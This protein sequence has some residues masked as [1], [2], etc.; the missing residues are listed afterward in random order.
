MFKS[1]LHGLLLLLALPTCVTEARAEKFKAILRRVEPE[2][3]IVHVTRAEPADDKEL[4]YSIVADARIIRGNGQKPLPDGLRDKLFVPGAQVTL[5]TRT[6]NG[7][8]VVTKVAVY[9]RAKSP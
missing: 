7:I 6:D 4:R 2:G 5:T 1:R 8:E 3:R 9:G